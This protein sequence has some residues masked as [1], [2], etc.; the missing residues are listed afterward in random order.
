METEIEDYDSSYQRQLSPKDFNEKHIIS[1]VVKQV[2]KQK[3]KVKRLNT[4][5]NL[6]LSE[7]KNKSAEKKFISQK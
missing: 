4:Q 3:S 2:V 5:C 1:K 6:Q 7:T